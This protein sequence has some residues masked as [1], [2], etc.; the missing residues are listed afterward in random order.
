MILRQLNLILMLK[1]QIVNTK[2]QRLEPLVHQRL[3]QLSDQRRLPSSLHAI[4]AYKEWFLW[5]LR[6]VE[7]KAREDEGDAVRGFVVY[8]LKFLEHGLS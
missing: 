7:L 2:D 8:D 4:K 3:L 5:V 6:A 1:I